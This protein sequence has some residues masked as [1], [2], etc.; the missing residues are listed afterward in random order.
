MI[1][2]QIIRDCYSKYIVREGHSVPEIKYNFHLSIREYSQYPQQPPPTDIP[3]SQIGAVKNRIL[4]VCTKHLGRVFLQKGKYNDAKRVF[5]IGRTWD[6]DELLCITRV[7]ADAFILLLNKDYYWKSGENIE[8]FLKFIHHLATIYSKFTG[9]YPAM[10]NFTLEELGL[11]P[12]KDSTSGPRSNPGPQPA[13]NV[14]KQRPAPT[15]QKTVAGPPPPPPGVANHYANMDFTANCKLPLKPMIVMEVDRPGSNTQLNEVPPSTSKTVDRSLQHSQVS[16]ASLD[17]YESQN[18]SVSFIFNPDEAESLQKHMPTISEYAQ[19]TGRTLPLRKY[20]PMVEPEETRKVSEPL[21]SAASLGDQLHDQLDGNKSADALNFQFQ[22]PT[23]ANDADFGIEEGILSDE[24]VHVPLRTASTATA[25][26]AKADTRDLAHQQ[27]LSLEIIEESTKLEPDSTIEHSIREIEDFMDNEFGNGSRLSTGSQ[28]VF[29][30]SKSNLSF[31]TKLNRDSLHAKTRSDTPATN[32]DSKFEFKVEKDAEVEEM[33]D[34]I[35]WNTTDSTDDFVKKLTK[36]LNGI[37]HKNIEE[38]RFLDFGKDTLANEVTV[39]AGEVDNLVEVFKKMEVSFHMIAPEIDAIESNSKGLQVRAVN[40]K[41]L[42]N[43]LSEILNK[44]R[45]SPKAL[46]SIT[47]Y[48]SFLDVQ[49]VQPLEENL[50]VL[51]E[52][53]GTIG[54]TTDD[55]LSNMKALKQFQD[56]Y[57]AASSTFVGHFVDFMLEEFKLTVE[58][59][60]Q[61][62]ETLYPRNLLAHIKNY[63]AYNGITNFMK[64]VAEKELKGLSDYLNGHFSQ[65]LES[66]LNIRLKSVSDSMKNDRSSRQ[67]QNFDFSSLRKSKQHR[68]GSTRLIN[69]LAAS[70]EDRRGHNRSMSKSLEGQISKPDEVSDPKVILRMIHET[71]ELIY[72]IQYFSGSFFH[73]TVIQ[74]YSEYVNNYPFLDRIRDLEDPELDLINYKSNSN[75]LLQSMTS[76]FG[77]YI[78]RF[79]KELTPN[80]LITPPLLVELYRLARDADAKNQDFIHYSF[81][82]KVIERYRGV[83]NKFIAG[84]VDLL[85]KSDVRSKAGILPVVRNLNQIFLS[86]ETSLQ[87]ANQRDYDDGNMEVA[88]LIKESYTKLTKAATEL[89]KR[90]DPLLKSN[91]HDDKERSHRSVAILQNVYAVILELDELSTSNTAPVRNEFSNV[92][93]AVQRQYFDYLLHRNLGKLI[94]FVNS[95]SAT[96][97]SKRKKDD[98]ILIRSLASTHTAKDVQPRIAELHHKL[99]KHIVVSNNVEEQDLLRKLWSDL[100][101]DYAM[102]FQKFDSIVKA[103]DRDVDLYATPSEVRRMFEHGQFTRR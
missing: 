89:F 66:L 19:A 14:Q 97:N 23:Q 35:G 30:D 57:S 4:T 74:E 64:W 44:V 45:V 28:Q 92:F 77:N 38:L 52:A 69:K 12:L 100:A 15:V 103:G 46:E 95:H 53:L 75:E 83:W 34:E 5:Q 102:V 78:N 18:D 42:Y 27:S 10:K 11:P 33:L 32:P 101:V 71:T 67:S 8:R 59:L 62:I 7:G 68:F 2:E 90:D 22:V 20:K 21:E 70:S 73:S 1:T 36:E 80:E 39:A 55:D 43:D 47:R 6:L 81:L 93:K 31:E 56:T 94:D 99:E 40:K 51:Y 61:E 49:T 76:V 82:F 58:E 9:R 79:I 65:F 13:L 3:P 84:Q 98:K 50:I 96:E 37:K 48:E 86:T 17:Q 85:N 88:E 87:E 16:L 60:N 41:I 26:L 72:V 54:S 24:E 91:S 63:L 25:S 29:E